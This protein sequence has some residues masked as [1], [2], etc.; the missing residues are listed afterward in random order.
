MRT[1]MAMA[2]ALL[3]LT[4]AAGTLSGH[5][6][7]RTSRR[8]VSAAEELRVMAAQGAW[9]RAAETVRAYQASWQ[10][11][12]SWLITIINHDDVDSVSLALARLEAGVAVRDAAMCIQCCAELRE[13]AEQLYQR[14]AFTLGNVL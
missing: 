7:A 1:S 2:A 12:R 14:D 9:T 11:E 3:A 4:L 10:K 8:Y 13:G 5:M 6:V